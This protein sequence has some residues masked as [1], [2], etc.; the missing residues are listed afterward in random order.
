MK[1]HSGPL[2]EH[3]IVVYDFLAARASKK[4]VHNNVP[5]IRYTVR[6]NHKKETLQVE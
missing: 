3:C 2:F 4:I 5:V 6:A 1:L